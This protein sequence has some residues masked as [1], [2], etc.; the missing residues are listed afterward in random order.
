ME[1]FTQKEALILAEYGRHV[2][3]MVKHAMLITDREERNKAA[4]TIILIMTQLNPSYKESEELQQ[5]LWDDLYIISNFELDVDAPYPKPEP[6]SDIRPEKVKYPDHNF[7]YKHYGKIIE[8]L[9][10][11][12]KKIEHADER[13]ELTQLIAN[14]MKKSYLNY[15]RDSV[16]E[17]MIVEQLT[18][19]SSGVLKL[20]PEF[21]FT[22]TNEILSKSRKPVSNIKQNNKN[23]NK[24]KW[25]KQ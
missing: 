9:I 16:S 3:E 18:S 11:S 8:G 25:K 2:Q 19:M 22:H 7:K 10:E 5:K 12:A 1:Y 13:Q 6:K 21:R 15:N 24:R 14:M 23:R 4:K 17:E 20:D